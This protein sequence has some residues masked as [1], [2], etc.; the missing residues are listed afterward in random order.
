MRPTKKIDD[1]TWDDVTDRDALI[2]R[3][4]HAVA[5][6]FEKD[7]RP[8][9]V[10]ILDTI[11]ETLTAIGDEPY[12]TDREIADSVRPLPSRRELRADA[13]PAD[14]VSWDAAQDGYTG[15]L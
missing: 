8:N 13:R 9:S 2:R 1:P 5:G 10:L 15:T 11:D 12:V 7:G 6:Q 3:L 14:D 4:C